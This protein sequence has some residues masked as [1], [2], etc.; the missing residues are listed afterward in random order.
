[1]LPIVDRFLKARD[2]LG[3]GQYAQL[4]DQITSRYLPAG[5]PVLYWD[6]CVIV[7]LVE[8]PRAPSRRSECQPVAATPEDIDQLCGLFPERAALFRRRVAEGQR[9]YVIRDGERIVARQ[10]I[11]DDRP[12]YDTNS[13]YCFVP[14]A[15]PSLWCHDIFVDPA[16]RMR[17]YFVALM[18]NALTLGPQG[19][20]PYLYGEI[21]FL[22]EASIRAHLGLG[23]R[24]IRTVT[25]V[26]VLGGKVYR[27]EDDEGN[28]R[29]QAR[30]AWRVRHI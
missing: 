25:V 5:N 26:S 8:P 10:W 19:Q 9:C 3:R 13:G 29:Y 22:N 6:R 28:A 4:A 12:A 18:R 20:R 1:M 2:L 17:G 24:V 15:R 14:P 27:L 21:H 11:V 30:H 7:G 16:C 23:Y